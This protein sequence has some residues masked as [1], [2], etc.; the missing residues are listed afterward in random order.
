MTSNTRLEANH[1][2]SRH[3]G[4]E[5][6][7]PR[8][9]AWE[10]APSGPVTWPDLRIGL[11]ASDRER[12]LVT[13]VHGPLMARQSSPGRR[14]KRFEPDLGGRHRPNRISS[15]GQSGSDRFGLDQRAW[16][17][18]A[19]RR[20]TALNCN[21][22]CNHACRWGALPISFPTCDTGLRW[23]TVWHGTCPGRI[24]PF[25]PCRCPAGLHCVR[26][27]GDLLDWLGWF[28]CG[29]SVAGIRFAYLRAA[30]LPAGEVVCGRCRAGH[31]C[32]RARD[33]GHG[34]LPR[35]RSASSAA[36]HGPRAGV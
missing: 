1:C 22:N 8:L 5:L 32:G 12:P 27:G 13:G 3:L 34:R 24:A 21:P 10:S 9:S 14:P 11:S 33:R 35:R 28:Q 15:S 2:P 26:G 30:G 19:V 23:V 16:S 36:V 20:G 4:G 25:M 6:A 18:L 7:E 17:V 29:Y 31:L